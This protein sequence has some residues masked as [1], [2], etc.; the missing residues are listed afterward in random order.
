[1]LGCVQLLEL[2]DSCVVFTLQHWDRFSFG[3]FPNFPDFGGISCIL[4]KIY[5][6]FIIHSDNILKF[7]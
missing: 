4:W 5:K 7:P 1:M 2:E 3:E 6:D